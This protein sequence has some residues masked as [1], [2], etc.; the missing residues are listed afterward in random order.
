[1]ERI[2]LEVDD[3]SGKAFRNFT[4]ESKKQF[5]IAVSMMLKKAIDDGG[6]ISY[7]K[8]LDAIGKEAISN[9]LTADILDKLL[10]SD[11]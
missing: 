2:V 6:I 10:E 8:M 7:S 1:M 9:G 3:F 4:P 11:D 5:N